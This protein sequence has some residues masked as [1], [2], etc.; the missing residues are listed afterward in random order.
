MDRPRQLVGLPLGCSAR[1]AFR[2]AASGENWRP[3][4]YK[5]QEQ[6]LQPQRDIRFSSCPSLHSHEQPGGLRNGSECC[7][8]P[9][10]NRLCVAI[11]KERKRL[12]RLWKNE[13]AARRYRYGAYRGIAK[14]RCERPAVLN[15]SARADS[16]KRRSPVPLI[17]GSRARRRRS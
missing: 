14:G 13:T 1:T 3:A 10:P 15:A 8:F 2:K 12:S 5:Q 11:P 6:L 9:C 7:S 16:Q 4:R 17:D